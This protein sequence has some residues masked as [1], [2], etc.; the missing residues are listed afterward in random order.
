MNRITINILKYSVLIITF[1]LGFY[2]HEPIEKA[3]S[4]INA[5]KVTPTYIA[6]LSAD[7]QAILADL[8]STTTKEICYNIAYDHVNYNAGVA[9]AREA[10]NRLSNV[11]QVE[12][13]IN[14]QLGRTS[15][16]TNDT[17]FNAGIAIED[18]YTTLKPI[19]QTILK[20]KPATIK[21]ASAT[22]Y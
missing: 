6:P 2:S 19:N 12:L 14:E 13:K 1:S 15:M 7:E 10:K 9:S 16:Y 11:R 3:L 8:N 5:K 17:N 18:A 4:F 22:H 21:D 20:P